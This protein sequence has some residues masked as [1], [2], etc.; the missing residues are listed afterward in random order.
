V[1]RIVLVLAILFFCS[2]RSSAQTSQPSSLP[3]PPPSDPQAVA[4]VQAAIT[5]LGGA[6]AIA[7]TQYWAFQ[8]SLS[9][10]VGSSSW[11]EIV[12]RYNGKPSTASNATTKTPRPRVSTSL[13]LPSLV[14]A[15]LVQE[16]Q[17]PYWVIHYSGPTTLRSEAVTQVVFSRARTAM[18]D[19]QTWYFDTATG[20]P[21]QVQFKIAAQIGQMRSPLGVVAL[22]SYQAVSGVLHPFQMVMSI[23]GMYQPEVVT[24]Q[25]LSA[26]A[27]DPTTPASSGG[28]Q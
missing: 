7:H 10:P 1:R 22:S 27:T 2:F 23:E 15:V 8:G 25:S 16:S 11:N 20:L 28:A 13:L 5:A 17:D 9:G 26:R 19:A 3:P 12:T 24:I 6:T 21:A 18:A 14:G 4:V